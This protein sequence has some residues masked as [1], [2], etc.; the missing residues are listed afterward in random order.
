M[1]DSSSVFLA[2]IMAILS[3]EF[4]QGWL[5]I[6]LTIVTTVYVVA[7]TIKLFKDWNKRS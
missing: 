4:L 5:G 6:V 2:A 7:K 3:L 1:D